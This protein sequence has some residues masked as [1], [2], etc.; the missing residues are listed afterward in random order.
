MKKINKYAVLLLFPV[1]FILNV[2]SS[3]PDRIIVA[4]NSEYFL[5]LNYPCIVNEKIKYT[6][7][8][9]K[10]IFKNEDKKIVLNTE[11]C[12][13]YDL[14]V[15]I[16]DKIPIK[17]IS[18]TIAPAKYIVP[19][20]QPVGVKIYTNGLLV[21]SVSEFITNDGEEVSPGRDAGIKPGDRIVEADGCRVT[22]TEEFSEIVKSCIET[23]KIKIL[24][25]EKEIETS[26]N[27]QISANE[28]MKK[29]GIW[30]RD[31]TAGI[32][33]M[34]Y[35]D[36]ENLSFAA[37]G[38]AICDADTGEVMTIGSGTLWTCKIM[39]VN[40]GRSGVPGE[41]L[42]SFSDDMIGHIS[43]NNELGI[44]GKLDCC[45]CNNFSEPVK[46]AT[47]FQVKTGE[48]FILSDVDGKGVRKYNIQIT[49]VSKS[50]AID[51]KGLV[52]KVNDPELIEKTGGIV[53]GMSGSPIIQDGMLV[54]AVTHVFVN[55]PTKGY[56]IFAENML[57][58]AE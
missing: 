36:S 20:G 51:N 15:K 42:G 35:Y 4:Q 55:D 32:G 40:K 58:N 1:I 19:S 54:G 44:Y 5:N 21:V 10:P 3:I 29:I 39:S 34:T 13:N 14:P 46:V 12:G 48:A 33:T 23:V 30:I 45:P 11:F 38:H 25:D 41:L 56:G 9:D 52:I 50:A 31:S 2:Y 24:R 27:P 17:T 28:K 43:K 57:N 16:F 7:L 49:K 8:S 22:S 37:L 53:Q 18:V 47:R 6:S 26:I